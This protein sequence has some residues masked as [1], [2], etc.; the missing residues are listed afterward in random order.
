MLVYVCKFW[1]GLDSIF[2]EPVC[3]LYT[4]NRDPLSVVLGDRFSTIDGYDNT[5][6]RFVDDIINST[7]GLLC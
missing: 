1:V 4:A 2:E 5:V 7:A 3:C 6:S